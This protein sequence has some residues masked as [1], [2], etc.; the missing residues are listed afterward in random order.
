MPL[1]SLVNWLPDVSKAFSKHREAESDPK[2]T[3]PKVVS[4]SPARG[5][6]E[7]G[8]GKMQQDFL[9]ILPMASSFIFR[10]VN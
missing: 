4:K 9:H 6:A 7:P 10:M 1:S 5:A 3:K 8:S 2:M